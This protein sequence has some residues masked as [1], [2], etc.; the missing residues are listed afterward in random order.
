MK[1]RGKK[2]I[3]KRPSVYVSCFSEEICN[4]FAEF[5]FFNT[6]LLLFFFLWKSSFFHLTQKAWLSNVARGCPI[7]RHMRFPQNADV[8]SHKLH[9]IALERFRPANCRL[10]FQEDTGFMLKIFF[11]NND[12]CW[13]L[14]SIVGSRSYGRYCSAW[15]GGQLLFLILIE[16]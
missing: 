12:P 13:P 15:E 14:S 9:G 2:K 7:G 11:N 8:C 3:P 5:F 1:Y 10:E 4:F 16:H 6:I